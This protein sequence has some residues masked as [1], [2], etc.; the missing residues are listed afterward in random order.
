MRTVPREPSVELRMGHG[1]LYWV[2]EAPADDATVAVGGAPLSATE[3]CIGWERRMRTVPVGPS[4]E[5]P[6]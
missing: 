4:V 5:F 6:M 1:A 3:G 2:G